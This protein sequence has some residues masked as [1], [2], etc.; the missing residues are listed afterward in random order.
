MCLSLSQRR[1]LYHLLSMK[2]TFC[3]Y[4]P[5]DSPQRTSFHASRQS[6]CLSS[7]PASSERRGCLQRNGGS[8]NKKRVVFADAKGL[9]LTAVR[10]FVPDCFPLA[11]TQPMDLSPTKHPSS[12]KPHRHKYRLGFPQPTLDL[13]A[14]LLRLR[15]TYVQLES[16]HISEHSL[17]GKVHIFHGSTDKAVHIRVTFDSWWHH[18]DIPCVFLQQ[19]RCGGSNVDVFAFDL[20]LPLNIDPT[21]GIE[22]C[23]S[24]RPG[25]GAST[26]WDNNRGQNYKVPG[27][28]EFH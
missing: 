23:V 9:P 2:P 17:S 25:G 27:C 7:S 20:S 28:T 26:H 11:S 22:F 5:T 21:E 24:F 10:L 14:L 6:L 4:E 18:H 15:E 1:P 19:Q 13:K 3:H 16:C 8:L 12:N